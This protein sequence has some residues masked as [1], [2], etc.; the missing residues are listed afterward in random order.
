MFITGLIMHEFIHGLTW[1][2]LG[3]LPWRQVRFGV[4]LKTFTIVK[5]LL[6]KIQ[7]MEKEL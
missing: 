4:Q 2:P 1:T 7:E 6:P 5:L 3:R